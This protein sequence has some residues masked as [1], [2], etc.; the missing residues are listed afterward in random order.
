MKGVLYS[1]AILAALS[2]PTYAQQATA[3]GVGQA[4]STSISNAKSTA[5]GV[6]GTAVG[7]GVGNTGT[8]NANPS[9]TVT[10]GGAPS[11]SAQTITTQG[12][13]SVS[14]VPSVFAPGLAAAGLESC[15]G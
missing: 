12:K 10:I 11:T 3:V 8:V 7:G 5:I 4:K 14:T 9:S 13:T 1:A 6:G 2:T 15:L